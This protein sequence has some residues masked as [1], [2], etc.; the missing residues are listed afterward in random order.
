MSGIQIDQLPHSCGHS[1]AL[2]VFAQDDGTVNGYCFACDTFVRHPY[3]DPV[4]IEDA[5]KRREK[6][7]EEVEAEIAEVSGYPVVDIPARKLRERTLEKFGAKV[8]MSEKDGK[9]PTAIYWPVTKDEKLTGYHVKVLDKSLPPFNMGNTRD[10]DLINWVNAKASGAYKLIVTEGP[11]DMASVDRIYEM[12]GDPDYHPAVVSLPHGAASAKKVLTKHAEDIRRI[13][14]E[15]VFCFDDDEAGRT[16]VKKGMLAIPYAKSVILPTKDANQALIEG[17][18][19]A[20]YNAL[21]FHASTPK[22]TSLVFGEALHDKSREPAKWGDLSWPFP[23]MNE[24]LR[25]IRYGETI[26]AGAG[27]KM[28]KSEFRDTMAAHFMQEHGVKVFMASPEEANTKTYKKLAGKLAGKIFHDPKIDFDYDAF[29]KAGQILTKQLAVIDLYQHIGWESLK[30]DMLAA[31]EWGAKAHF[32]DPITNLT[33]GVNSADANTM[34]QSIAQDISAMALDL[35]IVVFMFCH[36]KAPEGSISADQRAA[37]YKQGKYIGLGN[38]SHEMGGDVLSSQFAGSRA[39]MRSAN[40][41]IGLEGN[42]DPDLPEEVR[43]MRV[44]RILEDR[45]FGISEKFPIFW[46]RSTGKFIEL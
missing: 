39:M 44:I 3:G 13:F 42:K 31:A 37:K 23:K 5:P 16:A 26:Y 11:E 36:L 15:V 21:A 46:N 43:N 41:M 28:G 40:L 10:C 4:S 18:A 8:S 29:D 34:L 24:A 2:K 38:C 35:D 20:A 27:T 9:T 17:K 14:K 1:K 33:N 45:E 30:K 7:P 12:H 22:N 25:G 19:K 32:I 6:T